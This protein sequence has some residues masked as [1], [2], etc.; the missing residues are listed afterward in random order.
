[1]DQGKEAHKQAQMLFDSGMKEDA[2]R[3]L[4]YGDALIEE[5]VRQNVKQ[6]KR[7]LVPR[8]EAAAA[9]GAKLDYT[10]LMAKIRI[11]EGLGN[12]PP[13]GVKSVSLEEARTILATRFGATLDTVVEECAQ[14]IKD[15][16][17]VL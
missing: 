10:S 15:V 11:L 4:G 13:A 5:G 12:P 3:V 16:N 17:E 8:I 1:M 14:A 7:I 2:L 6:F 9:K